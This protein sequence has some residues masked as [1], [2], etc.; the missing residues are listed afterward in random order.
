MATF[1]KRGNKWRVEIARQGIRRSETFESK[2][3]A[4]AW[5]ARQEAEIMAGVRGEVPNL[6]VKALLERYRKEVSP[7][8]KGARWEEFACSAWS[9][10]NRS[11]EAP[12]IRCAARGRLADSVA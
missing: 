5:A 1:R 2:Q 3:A 4:V 9:A 8:K 11:G 6:T 12:A 10:T 7:A